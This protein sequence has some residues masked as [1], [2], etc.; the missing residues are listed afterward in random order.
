M[1]HSGVVFVLSDFIATGYEASL[2]RLAKKHDVVT[3]HFVDERETLVPDVGQI[4]LED[5]ETEQEHW[6]DTGSYAFREWFK[7]FTSEKEA[8]L[9]AAFKGNRI[10]SI[11]IF[12]HE[13]Y[14]DAVVKFFRAR[15]RR[16]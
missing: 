12:T 9:Q 4:L 15:S 2:R 14:G 3:L 8:T 1:K 5:P 11:R 6:I 10:E 16:R 13:N 7:T